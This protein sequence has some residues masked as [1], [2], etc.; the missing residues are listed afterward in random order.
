MVSCC[1]WGLFT[2]GQSPRCMHA[3][4]RPQPQKRT[5][6][7]LKLKYL[8]LYKQPQLLYWI[9]VS[10]LIYVKKLLERRHQHLK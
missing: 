1:Q 3:A 10:D 8:A 7:E 9:I 4:V 5:L 6:R 2:T